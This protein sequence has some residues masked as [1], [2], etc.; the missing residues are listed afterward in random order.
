MPIV[1]TFYIS[2]SAPAVYRELLQN[3]NDAEATK[4]EIHFSTKDG[5]VT[6]VLY[7]N[8][9][10][11]F[12]PQDWSRLKKI[13]EG[14]PDESKIGAFGVGFYSVFSICEEPLVISGKEALAFFWKGDALWTKVAANRTEESTWTSFVMPSRDT[15]PLPNL[16][17]FGEFLCSSLTFTKSLRELRVFVDEA[18]RLSILKSLIQEPRLVSTPKASSWFT[19][20]GAVTSS[21]KGTFSLNNKS[22][23]ESIYQIT[24]DLEGEVSSTE[25]RYVSALANTK[26]G[27]DMTK[28]MERVTKKNPPKTVNVEI[29]LNAKELNK[30]QNRAEQITN[31]FA[32]K[33]GAGRIFIGFRTSQTTGLAAH[34][35]APFVPTVEREAMDL[36]EPTLKIFNTELLEFAGILMRLSLDHAFALIDV[37]WQEGRLER[38]ELE[39]KLRQDALKNAE[40]KTKVTNDDESIASESG[41]SGIVS[42]AR[43]MARGVKKTIVSAVN[44]VEQMVDRGGDFMN[45]PDPRPLSDEERQ[46][47]LLMQSFCPQQSTPDPA[48]GTALAQGFSRCM[49]NVAPPV[50]TRSGVIRG[51]V[52]KL[53]HRGIEGFVRENVV[54]KI[55]YSNAQEYFTYIACSRQLNLDDLL[56]YL[57]TTVLE[58]KDVLR[59]LN[60]WTRYSRVDSYSSTMSKSFLLKESIRFFPNGIRKSSDNE[61]VACMSSFLFFVEKDSRLSGTLLPLPDTVL[62]IDFQNA[63]GLSVLTDSALSP[64]F[65]P[66]PID[67][68]LEFIAHDDI[69]NAARPEDEHKRIEVLVTLN[70]EFDKK[71]AQDRAAFGDLCRLNL[72]NRK[73]IPFDSDGTCS[74]TVPGDLYVFSAELEAF[75]GMGSFYKAS[76]LLKAAG[77]SEIFLLTLGVRKSV[78]IDFLFS[79][80]ETLKWTTDPKPLVEYLRTATLSKNDLAKLVRSKYLPAENDTKAYAPSELYLP[81]VDFRLFPFVRMLS[82]PSESEVSPRSENGKFLVSLGMKTVVPLSQILTHLSLANDQDARKTILEYLCERLGPNALYYDEYTRM[83]ATQKNQYKILP[84]V[85]NCMLESDSEIF[86]FR[87]P[88]SCYS[89]ASCSV[90]GFP[91]INP[92]LGDSAKVYGSLF[93]CP[94]EP[95]TAVLLEQLLHLVDK[96]KEKLKHA[97]ATSLDDI[98]DRIERTFHATFLY[99][100]HRT[101]DFTSAELNK[102]R[103][104]SFIPVFGLQEVIVQ[105]YSCDQV[106]FPTSE[107]SSDELTKELFPVL[108]SFNPFLA[109]VGGKRL[110]FCCCWPFFHAHDVN[111]CD[112][113]YSKT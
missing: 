105:W 32:P 58:Q 2:H 6:Q 28:R 25:A 109:A 112:T 44:S 3:S 113:Y 57:K 65:S 24:V 21:P 106:F 94:P 29:F 73:C 20:D 33:P 100:S 83:S 46:A 22:I 35:A 85:L 4:G 110:Y 68:W 111:S 91:I 69:M 42:F 10:M 31:S 36:Q 19:N 61:E 16:V 55:V 18:E 5:V 40:V 56:E 87:S 38:E 93:Q 50:L 67:I 108:K 9:G 76:E 89:T 103:Q 8:N 52:A 43:F 17:E 70:R 72:A 101:S 79:N 104:H 48:V 107:D 1:S 53:P 82:W 49:P 15:Y 95:S 26:I 75:E 54:R 37:S 23:Y 92:A 11:P 47:I 7:R 66:L 45:P 64:W 81:S 12:R 30:P 62:P 97:T 74:A 13:A 71:S 51:D 98:A 78:S 59:L 27:S 41:A 77:V 80:L 96:A 90:M 88:V 60:W 102:L 63:I 86:E 99:L 39:K 34:L 84:C 14:N